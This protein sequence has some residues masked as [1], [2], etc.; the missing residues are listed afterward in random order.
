[1]LSNPPPTL[2]ARPFAPLP[3]ARAVALDPWL[4]PLPGPGPAPHRVGRTLAAGAP[5]PPP[6]LLVL[7]SEFFT[8]WRDHF[9][10]L[11]GVVRAWD[12]AA[13]DAKAEA[14]AAAGGRGA[15]HAWLVTLVR[16]KHVSFSDFG[17][18][19]PFGGYARD[20]R[21][22]L[23]VICELAD[24]FLG[25]GFEEALGRQS[26]VEFEV[27]SVEEKKGH[28]KRRIVGGVGDI[29]VH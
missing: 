16:A 1:M 18:V 4:E 9:A 26:R 7:N 5:H 3:I 13:P 12:A 29:V 28:A 27:E 20:A 8:L 19:V 25:G 2:Q 15:Q 10:R 21:R 24:A 11:Q 23:D 6:A 14:A 17:V 22:F